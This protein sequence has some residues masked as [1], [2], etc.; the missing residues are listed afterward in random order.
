[1]SPYSAELLLDAAAVL[2]EADS[3]HPG[4]RSATNLLLKAAAPVVRETLVTFQRDRLS[5]PV[6]RGTPTLGA[7]EHEA[8]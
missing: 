3:E 7:A 1:M 5:R 6:R 2:D 8:D 4:R